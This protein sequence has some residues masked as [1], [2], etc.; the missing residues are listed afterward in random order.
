[1]E[2]L[3]TPLEKGYL[4]KGH[5]KSLTSYFAVPKGEDDIRIVYD[6]SKCGLNERL[7]APNFVLPTIDS[8]L[9]SVD[10]NSWFC[11]ADLGEMFLNYSLESDLKAYAGVDCSLVLKAMCK[12]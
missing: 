7:W 2:K 1:M 6:A 12:E 5:I 9:R 4:E 10:F 11:D 3:K 8:V